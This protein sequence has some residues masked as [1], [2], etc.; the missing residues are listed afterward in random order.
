MGH[1]TAELHQALGR[2]RESIHLIHRA[3]GVFM[4]AVVAG[5][6]HHR[7]ILC[8]LLIANATG[9]QLPFACRGR[10]IVPVG[11]F[12]S[13]RTSELVF[14]ASRRGDPRLSPSEDGWI[15]SPELDNMV[16]ST[17]STTS[18]PS[19][20]HGALI[21]PQDKTQLLAIPGSTCKKEAHQNTST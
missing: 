5:Q 2:P 14:E 18:P 1:E 21:F 16:T 19:S 8:Q 11:G 10:R 17:T 12:L 9:L 7:R 6:F 4:K 13:R 15:Q 20:P 3:P